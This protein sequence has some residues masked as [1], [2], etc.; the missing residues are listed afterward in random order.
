MNYDEVINFIEP[1]SPVEKNDCIYCPNCS[2]NL[3]TIRRYKFCPDCGQKLLY[4]SGKSSKWDPRHNRPVI[5]FDLDD[6]VNNFTGPLVDIFNERTGAEVKVE[7][8]KDW[9]LSKYLGE[10]G[11]SIFR[12][13]GFFENLPEKNNSL[14]VLKTLIQSTDYDVYIVT[15]C[16]TNQELEEKFKWFDKYLPTFNKDRIIKCKEKEIIRGDVL[17]DDNV[18]NLRK[19][20]PYMRC[21]LYDMPHNRECE[22]FLRIH[23]LEEVLPLL[24][25]WFY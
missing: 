10:Y 23:S 22:E 25:E 11:I 21:I 7:D 18:S 6:T 24:K 16:G 14:S 15:A 8:I 13:E 9:D 17:V 19:C 3:P 5:L 4:E 20:A 12:E 2:R 1:K